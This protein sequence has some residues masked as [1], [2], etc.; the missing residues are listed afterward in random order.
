[1]CLAVA[2]L[3]LTGKAVVV[4]ALG[5]TACV[6]LLPLFIAGGTVSAIFAASAYRKY[7]TSRQLE[8]IEGKLGKIEGCLIDI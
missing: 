8:K 4:I 2:L 7:A 3:G 5:T 6:G 1:M